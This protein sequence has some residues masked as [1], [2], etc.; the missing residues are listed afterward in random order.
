TAIANEWWGLAAAWHV[1]VGG[2]LISLVGGWR[3]SRRLFALTISLSTASVSALAWASDNPF[4]GAVF[5]ALSL[6]LGAVAVGFRDEPVVVASPG[7]RLAG[8]ALIAFGWI[9]PHFLD[10]TSGLRYLYAS[11]LG[12]IP[13]PTLAA[14]IGLTLIVGL[15]GLRLWSGV[16]GATGML[17]GL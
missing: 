12:L 9:Y 11:P 1:V 16:L 4:N 15:S 2:L 17:Y 6:T 13:C 7:R 14:A 5:G 8:A 3:P 10:A